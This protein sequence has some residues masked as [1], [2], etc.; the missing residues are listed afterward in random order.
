MVAAVGLEVERAV[1][2]MDSPAMLLPPVFGHPQLILKPDLDPAVVKHVTLHEIAHVIMGDVD[3][4]TFLTW[5]GPLPPQEDWADL[6]SLVALLDDQEA[7][8]EVDQVEARIL[9]LVPLDVRG[10]ASSRVPRLAGKIGR[11]KTMIA[12]A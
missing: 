8:D 10:W 2:P 6:F 7:A 1:L 4:L 12:E 9:E 3:E 5:G 11:L